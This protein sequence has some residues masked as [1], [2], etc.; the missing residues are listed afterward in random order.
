MEHSRKEQFGR[1]LRA[2]ISK[3]ITSSSAF[4]DY[5]CITDA[6]AA[7]EERLGLEAEKF[8]E[9]EVNAAVTGSVPGAIK[10]G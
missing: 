10:G 9:E 7:E 3:H 8:S 1:E 2:L 5:C 6:L 4:E